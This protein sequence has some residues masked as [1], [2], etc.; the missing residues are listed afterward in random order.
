MVD[1]LNIKRLFWILKKEAIEQ[2]LLL[3][4]VSIL[5]PFVYLILKGLIS[6]PYSIEHESIVGLF[7]IFLFIGGSVF[8]STVFSDLYDKHKNLSW[9]MLPASTL[10]KF[11]AQLILSTVFYIGILL[12]GFFFASCA[13]NALLQIALNYD[14]GW[15]HPFEPGVWLFISKFLLFHA[16][17]F[18]GAAY[19]KRYVFIKTIA[20]LFALMIVTFILLF[21][22]TYSQYSD[23]LFTARG[24]DVQLSFQFLSDYGQWIRWT[25]FY[26]LPPL[27]WVIAYRKIRRVEADLAI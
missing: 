2:P 7:T 26:L 21:L 20:F 19:F 15:F 6:H 3:L 1:S 24:V 17:F 18:L 12:L 14:I 13:A 5:V 25:V 22:I 16:L 11:L 23:A 27:F 10:E 9:L 4:T 8:A